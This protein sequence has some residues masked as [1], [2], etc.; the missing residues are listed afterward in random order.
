MKISKIIVAGLLFLS[1]TGCGAF[2]RWTARMTGSGAETCQDGVIYLQFTS[3][4]SVKY[5]QN[6]TIATCSK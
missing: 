5:N 1:L 4:V 3:G 6:G 2:D